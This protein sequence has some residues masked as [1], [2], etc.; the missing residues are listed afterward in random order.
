MHFLA[1]LLL[2][3]AGDAIAFGGLQSTTVSPE[4]LALAERVFSAALADGNDV[5]GRE[6]I[7]QSPEVKAALEQARAAALDAQTAQREFRLA[8]AA[9]HLDRAVASFENADAAQVARVELADALEL[10]ARLAYALGKSD[11][12]RAAFGKLARVQ[13]DRTLDAGALPPDAIAVH[14][15]ELDAA[16]AFAPDAPEGTTL[17]RIARRAGTR[18]AAAGE[19][20]KRDGGLDFA[21]AIA[22]IDGTIASRSFRVPSRDLLVASVERAVGAMSV[23]LGIA[24]AAPVPTPAPIVMATPRPRPT[25]MALH[26]RWYVW[27]GAIAAVSAAGLAATQ[28][29]DRSEPRP[30]PDPDPG[31]TVTFPAPP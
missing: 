1:A 21:L 5:L 11:E 22:S 29:G 15:Q 18:W 13:P 10:R 27:A 7:A 2:A 17:A 14:Q 12:M 19:V 6:G 23:E 8:E 20:R 4:D 16:R 9:A 26:R 3:T 25:P 24:R 31:V 28:L 30:V